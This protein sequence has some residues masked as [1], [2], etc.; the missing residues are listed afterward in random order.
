[1]NKGRDTIFIALINGEQFYYA[2]NGRK[3]PKK[4][5]IA[6]KISK[7]K[8]LT[9]V[10]YPNVVISHKS[11]LNPIVHVLGAVNSNAYYQK[12]ELTSIISPHALPI[13]LTK[14]MCTMF[15]M[16][17]CVYALGFMLHLFVVG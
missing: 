3:D 2:M 14:V 1:M 9:K 11:T 13:T 17:V 15:C 12:F 7:V 10:S 8:L 5:M 16:Y 4:E 6:W